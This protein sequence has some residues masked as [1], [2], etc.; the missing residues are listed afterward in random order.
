[1]LSSEFMELEGVE[2]YPMLRSVARRAGFRSLTAM[3]KAAG[4]KIQ[5]VQ[6]WKNTP[7]PAWRL[8]QTL[9]QTAIS[10]MEAAPPQAPTGSGKTMEFPP[11]MEPHEIHREL[12]KNAPDPHETW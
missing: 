12:S 10:N 8:L 11:E 3:C 4:V 2:L 7:P 9:L 1:M 6:R 5:N